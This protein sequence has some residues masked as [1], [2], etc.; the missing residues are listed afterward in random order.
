M[1]GDDAERFAPTGLPTD[2]FNRALRATERFSQPGNE[3]LIGFAVNRRRMQTNLQ[4]VAMNPR[5]RGC[6]GAGLYVHRDLQI[7]F[8]GDLQPGCYS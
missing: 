2:Q 1:V 3:F 6:F 8:A 4:G 5:A 7:T